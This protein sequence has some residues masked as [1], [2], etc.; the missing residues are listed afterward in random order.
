MG[1][2]TI[3]TEL[4]SL[5]CPTNPQAKAL[6][7][8]FFQKHESLTLSALWCFFFANNHSESFAKKTQSIQQG[9]VVEEGSFRPA[10]LRNLGLFGNL[11][12][13][14]VNVVRQMTKNFTYFQTPTDEIFT[15]TNPCCFVK[16]NSGQ[17]FAKHLDEILR[18]PFHKK[19]SVTEFCSQT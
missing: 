12:S 10:N 5:K 13:L 7:D 18:K 14:K 15:C 19:C 9:P 16:K 8:G 11:E 4:R 6:F 2:E 1:V 17:I 3:G